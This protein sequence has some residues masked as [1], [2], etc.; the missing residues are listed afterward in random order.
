MLAGL[1][2]PYCQPMPRDPGQTER[3]VRRLRWEELDAAWLRAFIELARAEDLAGAGLVRRPLRPGDPS[4]DLL[5]GTVRARARIV[6][7]RPAVIAGLGLLEIVFAAYGHRCHAKPLAYDGQFVPADTAVAEV[8]GP[9]AD[10]LSAE[11]ILLNFLQRLC[12]VATRTREHV[13]ALGSSPT[14]LLDTRKTTPGFRMLEKYAVGQGGGYNHR[15]GLFDRIMV[16][17]NHLAAGSAGAAKRLTAFVERARASRP[18]LIVEVEVDRL[19]QIKPVV[20]AGADIVLLDNF[21]IA[22][23]RE[24]IP[25]LRGKAWSEVSGGVSLETLPAIGTLSPDFVSCGGITH[26]APWCD[27]GM[28]W[29]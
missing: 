4:A 6:T 14:K 3:L 9:A 28:D 5:G 22:D 8:E 10:L 16:K 29:S 11:R 23:L 18:D 15:L 24:A 27:L 25:M 21:T 20:T 12:G 7:R 26:S 17:D 19:D 2:P 13:L 1:A